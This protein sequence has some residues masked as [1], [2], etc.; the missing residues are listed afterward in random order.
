[1]ERGVTAGQSLSTDIEQLSLFDLDLQD[2]QQAASAQDQDQY[3]Q[4][5][6]AG[7]I[8]DP[9][10]RAPS[11]PVRHSQLAPIMS[12]APAALPAVQAGQHPRANSNS[13]GRPPI[14]RVSAGS[15]GFAAAGRSGVSL[16][17]YASDPAAPPA[18]PARQAV[19][20]GSLASPF[21]QEN[22]SF[23]D[24]DGAGS[25]DAHDRTRSALI[26]PP[27]H[28]MA[29]YTRNF[30]CYMHP[31][32]TEYTCL[33]AATCVTWRHQPALCCMRAVNAS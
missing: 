4:S 25:P 5:A 27:S 15:E 22:V 7:G 17:R 24:D 14:R 20:V 19:G 29:L 13:I 9:V 10:V 18:L 2:A 8:D 26:S 32:V 23:E 30:I 31:V 12:R 28:S 3:A 21:G 33:G 16:G 1:M 6:P 11:Q